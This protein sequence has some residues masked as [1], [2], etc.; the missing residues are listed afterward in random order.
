MTINVDQEEIVSLA[1]AAKLLPRVNG[2]RAAVS[3]V[4][5]WCRK[6][7]NGTFLEYV[8]VGRNIA[9]SRPALNRFFT[10][11][12]AADIPLNDPTSLIQKVRAQNNVTRLRQI[13][14]SERRLQ[15]MGV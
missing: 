12:A 7:I 6:G 1:E 2:K 4:W 3:T 11:L 13:E 5:R 9:T 15:E 10:A 8:R 14:A